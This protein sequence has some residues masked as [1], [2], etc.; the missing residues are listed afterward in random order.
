MAF[1][2]DLARHH[3]IGYVTAQNSAAVPTN[4]DKYLFQ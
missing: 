2:K 3:L 1:R 4:S